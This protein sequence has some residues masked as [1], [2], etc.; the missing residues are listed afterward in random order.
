MMDLVFI[1]GFYDGSCYRMNLFMTR[2]EGHIYLA[3]NKDLYLEREDGVDWYLGR[4][5]V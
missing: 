2:I 5:T 3:R 1:H 4:I